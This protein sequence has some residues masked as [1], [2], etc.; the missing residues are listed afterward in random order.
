MNKKTKFLSVIIILSCTSLFAYYKNAHMKVAEVALELIRRSDTKGIYREIY[1]KINSQRIID[2][3]WQED[4][5]AVG[6]H[7]RAFRH[8]W[9]PDANVGCP[10][11]SYF[12]AMPALMPG[13]KADFPENPLKLGA[14][15]YLNVKFGGAFRWHYPG[16]LEWARNGAASGDLRNWEGAIKAYS[17]SASSRKQAYWRLGHVVHLVADMAEPD[18]TANVP[19][20]ASGFYYP[21]DL[22]MINKL[23]KSSPFPNIGED[24][25]IKYV[26]NRLQRRL[27]IQSWN[28]KA[29]VGFE[30]FV[31]IYVDKL[32]PSA[33]NVEIAKRT[34]FDTY[35][36]VLADKSKLAVRD[37]YEFPLPLGVRFN[38]EKEQS[39]VLA[40]D[41]NLKNWSF[42]PSINYH[43]KNEREKFLNLTRNLLTFAVRLDA[44]IME[45][46][47]DIVDPPP[48]VR[49]V[50]IKQE[51]ITRYHAW[52]K[53]NVKNR[54]G[55]HVNENEKIKKNLE[56]N[57]PH[58]YN[59]DVVTSRELIRKLI[60]EGSHLLPD[61]VASVT[62]KFGPDP[63]GFDYPP[64]KIKKAWIMLGDGV[65]EE[66]VH[67]RD[68][69]KVW[70]GQFTPTLDE[71]EEE[72]VLQMEIFARDVHNHKPNRI[73]FSSQEKV[74]GDKEYQLD[75][76][77]DSPAKAMPVPPYDWQSYS[78]GPDINH[79][80]K[81]KKETKDRYVLL[82]TFFP[83]KVKSW[84]GAFEKIYMSSIK[85]PGFK[86]SWS[87]SPLSMGTVKIIKESEYKKSYKESS[88]K[89]NPILDYILRAY[90]TGQ[91]DKTKSKPKS[92]TKPETRSGAKTGNAAYGVPSNQAAFSGVITRKFGISHVFKN[93]EQAYQAIS[94]LRI[95]G[96]YHVLTK[97]LDWDKAVRKACERLGETRQSQFGK[98]EFRR[99]EHHILQ[100]FDCSR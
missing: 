5:G 15:E 29:R 60:K 16:A 77:P 74:H 51:G 69:G 38:P 65:E 28:A 22:T 30:E 78:P 63:E 64:E 56:K 47:H 67:L 82:Y 62:I 85:G 2:G 4:V 53:D 14:R 41:D 72:F 100:D 95:W 98:L 19:H 10:W 9:D 66:V 43:D 34:M 55:I 40:K 44:G 49:S 70:T 76:E 27:Q 54:A 26:M 25:K 79:F 21:Q 87:E 32:F 48:Y 59:Y 46:F 23:I 96:Y 12:L 81:V 50:E 39:E 13:S 8:Y 37:R 58:E 61:K 71:G 84:N 42:F 6:G 99:N 86:D 73:T 18:H 24:K 35:F 36:S 11:F 33:P 80:V 68:R 88:Y 83:S 92:K 89:D 52:W 91:M 20:A 7:D 94:S 97:D 17:Y 31:E 57:F 1:S 3:S 90:I 75:A 93:P 45:F